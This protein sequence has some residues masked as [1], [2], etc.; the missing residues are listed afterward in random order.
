MDSTMSSRNSTSAG[1]E[2]RY[3]VPRRGSSALSTPPPANFSNGYD[4]KKDDNSEEIKRLSMVKR[5]KDFKKMEK[6]HGR[7][8]NIL[9]GLELH[10]GVFSPAEQKQIV[11]C[12]YE[13][14]KKGQNGEL[15]ERT[16]S[17]P[18]KWMRGKGRITIQFGCCYNYAVDKHGNPPGIIRDEEVD[19]IPPLLKFMIK[20]MV[21]W[22]VL[23]TTCIP[24]SCIVNIYDKD[25][26]IP[27]HIDHHDFLRP[28]CTVSFLS[29]CNILFG[30]EM[31]VLGPGE[32]SGSTA[33]PLPLG[34]VLILNGNGAE[35]A[36]HCVPAVPSRRISI[37]FRKMDDS[38]LPFKYSL[39]PD[40]LNLRALPTPAESARLQQTRSQSSSSVRVVPVQQISG[41]SASPVPAA[42][43]VPGQQN[44]GESSTPVPAARFQ[45]V[46]RQQAKSEEVRPKRNTPNQFNLDDFPPLGFGSAGHSKK[47]T[48]SLRQ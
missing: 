41:A 20:R 33:I 29:E 3:P 46:H 48:R 19:P 26:C 39:D 15:R 18:R 1:L 32:F 23:P 4:Q 28:F 11:D 34:S 27:P 12:I 9:E 17:E 45:S 25:D 40:L 16:Y 30:T 35:I 5:K 43:A 8:V 44:S 47:T 14:Q 7:L 42:P 10:T 22:H 36:K 24:N 2:R 13:F 31:K 6:V 38:K 21:A 37:T